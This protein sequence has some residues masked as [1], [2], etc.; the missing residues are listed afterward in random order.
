MESKQSCMARLLDVRAFIVA[1]RRA[2]ANADPGALIG[3]IV[4]F[5]IIALCL[6]PVWM[7]FDLAST[8]EFTTAIRDGAQPVIEGALS[9]NSWIDIS[10]GQMIA[11][12]VLTS[13]TLLPTLFELAFPTVSH[14]LLSGA[15]WISII[16]DFT[17]DWGKAWEVTAAWAGESGIAHFLYA[18]AF[19][20]FSS[21]LCQALLVISLTVVVFGVV[22]LMR[23]GRSG[24][25]TMVVEP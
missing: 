18:L 20:W 10:L 21:L 15:L 3:M 5:G 4:V 16:Y 1:A 22:G 6:L 24:R 25:R 19:C 2:T 13:F 9:S 8:W 11:G 17:T 23:G 12:I 7:A 14:P